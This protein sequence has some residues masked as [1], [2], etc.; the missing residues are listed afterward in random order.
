MKEFFEGEM[1]C[2][3]HIYPKFMI[4]IN[5]SSTIHF[6]KLEKIIKYFFLPRFVNYRNI[7]FMT[8]LKKCVEKFHHLQEVGIPK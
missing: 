4:T 7:K 3:H 2:K 8:L 5:Y 1:I 6:L